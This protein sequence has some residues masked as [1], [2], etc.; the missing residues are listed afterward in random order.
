MLASASCLECD[1]GRGVTGPATPFEP[2]LASALAV[3]GLTGRCWLLLFEHSLRDF[4]S[5]IGPIAGVGGEIR[6]LLRLVEEGVTEGAGK[7]HGG[8]L[9]KGQKER[10][11]LAASASSRSRTSRLGPDDEAE[12]KS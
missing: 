12:A 11:G 6:L 10:K 9:K 4:P 2:S 7:V 8:C 5:F 3:R 1:S